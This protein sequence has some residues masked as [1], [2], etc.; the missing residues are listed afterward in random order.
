MFR[1]LTLSSIL[2]LE[3]AE[4][5]DGDALYVWAATGA[6][7][8]GMPVV[9]NACSDIERVYEFGALPWTVETDIDS[10]MER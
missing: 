10:D 1:K 3:I 2:W 8:D 4:Y 5:G 6:E 7:D 9:R